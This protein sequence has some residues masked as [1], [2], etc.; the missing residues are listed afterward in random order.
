[1][2]SSIHQIKVIHR[3]PFFLIGQHRDPFKQRLHLRRREEHSDFFFF[4]FFKKRKLNKIHQQILLVFLTSSFVRRDTMEGV[5]Q[6]IFLI[7]NNN[8]IDQEK[9][10]T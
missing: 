2:Y 7:S 1:M 10:S 3:D 5:E 9:P 8:F 6:N 4:F